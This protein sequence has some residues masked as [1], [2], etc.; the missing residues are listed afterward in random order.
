M[1]LI[2]YEPKDGT[3]WTG[4]F[5]S[6][7]MTKAR[8]HFYTKQLSWRSSGSRLMPQYIREL[9]A[10]KSATELILQSQ[11]CGIIETQA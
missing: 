2:L 6:L 8:G 5:A 4:F 3:L 10:N 7:R 9:Q 1:I 11:I